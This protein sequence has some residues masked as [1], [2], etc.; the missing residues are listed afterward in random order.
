[1]TVKVWAGYKAY[2]LQKFTGRVTGMGKD[3]V[4]YTIGQNLKKHTLNKRGQFPV[5]KVETTTKA[6][7]HLFLISNDG[8]EY[9]VRLPDFEVA[10]REGHELTA[11]KLMKKSSQWEQYIAIMNHT[12]RQVFISEKEIS[13]LFRLPLTIQLALVAGCFILG[14]LWNGYITGTIAVI[15][16]GYISLW[17]INKTISQRGVKK[18]LTSFKEAKTDLIV[19]EPAA[20]L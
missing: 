2:Y 16:P 4:L 9:S 13:K 1:M 6:F 19:N 7:N 14:S 20:V 5:V 15:I 8:S 3:M 10:C 11:I 17:L 12:T 18:L